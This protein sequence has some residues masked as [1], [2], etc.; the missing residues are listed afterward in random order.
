MGGGGL[1]AILRDHGEKGRA[2]QNRRARKEKEDGE[3]LIPQ[4]MAVGSPGSIYH[5]DPRGDGRRI[6]KISE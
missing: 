5:G 3:T 1:R 2:Q 4:K 6:R